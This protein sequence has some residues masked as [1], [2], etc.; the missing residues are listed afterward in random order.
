VEHIVKKIIPAG[1]EFLHA[2]EHT[3]INEA[4]NVHLP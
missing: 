2:Y 1:V 3:D 4:V